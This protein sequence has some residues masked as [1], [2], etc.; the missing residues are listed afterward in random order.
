[1]LNILED[2]NKALEVYM[3]SSP[4]EYETLTNR[5]NLESLS[6]RYFMLRYYQNTYTPKQQLQLIDEFEE[7]CQIN[8]VT[9][10]AESTN[11]AQG[12][13]TIKALLVSFRSNVK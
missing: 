9:N 2:A 7:I 11:M 5:I 1:M 8:N 6:P 13:N 3:E 12:D 10:W 4:T